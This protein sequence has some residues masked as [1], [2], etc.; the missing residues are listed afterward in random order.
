MTTR[1]EAIIATLR[2]FGKKNDDD[3]ADTAEEGAD[4]LNALLP[5]AVSGRQAVRS[6]RSKMAELDKMLEEANR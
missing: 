5:E 3:T 4:A 6:Q 1:F 2:N